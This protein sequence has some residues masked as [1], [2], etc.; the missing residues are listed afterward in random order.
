[1]IEPTHKKISIRRQCDL[2]GLNRSSY[3]Y[4]SGAVDCI[5]K[6]L[7]VHIISPV[8]ETEENLGLMKQID[9][10]Y[11][12]WPFYGSRK[13]TTVLNREGCL[14]NRKRIQ[15]LMRLMGIQAIY[16]KPRLSISGQDHKIY[17]YLLK[18]LSIERPDQVWC[19]D[20]TYL[21]LPHGFVYLVAILDWFSRFVLAWRLSNT[22][23]TAFCLEALDD[24]LE[25]RQPPEIFNTDQGCQFTSEAHT[26]CLKEAGIKISMDGR[27]RVFDNI[28][29]ERLW[30]SLKYEDIY[31]KDYQTVMELSAGLDSY[32]QFYNYERPHQSLE[33]KTPSMVYYGYEYQRTA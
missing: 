23:D 5:S 13:M 9:E 27:G 4:Q 30:R 15:R 29:I 12:K 24:A 16:P 22:L 32:F 11:M 8:K 20:I 28:F 31:I 7:S 26:G 33:D 25:N 1:M 18:D 3:Y 19:A 14:V 10:L 21:L 17:P 6:N 2:L